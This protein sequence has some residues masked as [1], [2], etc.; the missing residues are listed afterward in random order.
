MV[1]SQGR[2]LAAVDHASVIATAPTLRLQPSAGWPRHLFSDLWRYRELV[3][4]FVWR[5]IKVRY[6]QTALGAAWA[7]IQPVMTTI[8]FSIFFG[9]L[10]HV[11]SDGLPYPVFSMIG[12]RPL[13]VLSRP[14][15]GRAARRSPAISTSSR[16][17]IS[18]V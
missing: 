1:V 14:R 7:I 12:A 3:F 11:P 8:V 5:D 10:A 6:K 15:S 17:S 4:F 2:P 16:R 9:R 18:P 13:D